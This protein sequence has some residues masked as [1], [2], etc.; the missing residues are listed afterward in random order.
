MKR[1]IINETKETALDDAW[2]IS[3]VNLYERN[4]M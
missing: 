1:I 4:V 3:D 2:L